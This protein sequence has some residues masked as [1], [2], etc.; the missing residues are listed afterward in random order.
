MA[1]AHKGEVALR[2]EDASYTLAFSVNAFCAFEEASGKTFASLVADLSDPARMSMVLVRQFIHA[3]LL[4]HHPDMTL[5]DAGR[6]VQSAG[7]VLPVMEIIDRAFRA[8]MPE[9]GAATARPP[10]RPS[11]RR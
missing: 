11:R 4:E 1:N 8:A 5:L 3:L 7:G 6:L 9:G 10:Q 2:I